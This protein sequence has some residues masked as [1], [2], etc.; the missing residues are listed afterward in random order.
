MPWL[1]QL[2][3]VLGQDGVVRV[4]DVDTAEIL[5]TVG[6]PSEEFLDLFLVCAN[7]RCVLSSHH[8]AALSHLPSPTLSLL[9]LNSFT[10]SRSHARP[11]SLA[12]CL[13]PP[14]STPHSHTLTLTLSPSLLS[15]QYPYTLTLTLSP[16][17]LNLQYSHLHAHMLNSLSR[18]LSETQPQFPADTHTQP[19]LL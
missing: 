14:I 17:I 5:A 1:L 16:S 10:T 12:F 6:P 9:I 18:L 7:G 19:F 2:L 8:Q 13:K 3:A 15:L 11:R 4:I